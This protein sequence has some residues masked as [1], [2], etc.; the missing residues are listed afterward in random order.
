VSAAGYKGW[1]FDAQT[2]R[3]DLKAR[4]VLEQ[5]TLPIYP[6]REH[7]LEVF[8]ALEQYIKDYVGLN[9]KNQEDI[10][11]DFELQAFLTDVKR[12]ADSKFC[13]VG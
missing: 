2:P 4:G 3:A 10:A 5:S 13:I 6:Y 1:R 7:A 8:D 9:Y 11:R 12:G